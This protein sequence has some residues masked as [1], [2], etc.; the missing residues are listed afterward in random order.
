LAPILISFRRDPL[1]KIQNRRAYGGPSLYRRHCLRGAAGRPCVFSGWSNM[2]RCNKQHRSSHPE[3]S[4]HRF[5]RQ[6]F[7]GDEASLV[8]SNDANSV[9]V[10]AGAADDLSMSQG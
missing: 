8:L 5:C 6:W 2:A 7:Y 10:N 1:R 9:L 3:G 4:G